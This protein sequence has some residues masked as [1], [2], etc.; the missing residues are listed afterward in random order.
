MKRIHYNE[1]RN[2]SETS[3]RL[4]LGESFCFA[5]RPFLRCV[6]LF[7]SFYTF[8]EILGVDSLAMLV[9][10]FFILFVSIILRVFAVST[11]LF[12]TCIR[13]MESTWFQLLCYQT[14]TAYKN[15]NFVFVLFFASCSNFF[16]VFI[17]G[18]SNE[19]WI[20]TEMKIFFLFSTLFFLHKITHS[21]RVN[22]I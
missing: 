19:K 6:C 17:N 15:N 9:L 5:H 7:F 8:I 3:Y 2:E 16:S 18:I 22:D 14:H 10:K 20:I 1:K 11:K 21:K 13:Q 12:S 4:S